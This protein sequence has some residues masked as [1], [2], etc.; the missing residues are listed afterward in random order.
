MVFLAPITLLGLLLVSLPVAI[1]LLV[2]RRGRR[3][4]FP[5]LK[6]LRETPS[7]KLYP[8]R[9]RQP[10]LLA[11]RAAAIIL[12]VMGLARP[13]FTSSAQ[14]PE[15][16]RFILID[17]SLSMKMRGRAETASEQARAII[18]KL[19][20]S[21]R[22]SVIALSS[23]AMVLAELT[24]DRE[25]LL[26]AVE[27]YQPTGG[28]VNYRAGFAA[29]RAQL[30]IEPQ[31]AV[32]ADIISDFQE[33][34]FEERGEVISPEAAQFR[35]STYEIGSE[36]ERNAFLT[37]EA[38]GKTER[39]FELSASEIV[40]EAEGRSGARR[41]WTIEG[42]EVASPEIE[43]RTQ[44][45]NQITGR[46]KVLEPDDFDADDERFFAFTPPGENRVLLA[47]D[48]K[49]A[50]LY[51]NAALEAGAGKEAAMR[52]TLDRRKSLPE[53][54]ADLA[55]FSLIVVT[56]HGGA[57]ENEARTLTEYAR[58]GGTV[59]MLTAR[60]LDAASWSQLASAEAGQE[61]PF[62]SVTR[63]N[64]NQRLTFGAMDTDAPQLRELDESALA[65]LRSVRV[66][67]SYVVTPRPQTD[68][69]MRW[70]DGTPAFIS[71]RVGSGT[72]MLLATSPERASSE[73]GL[74][75]SFPALVS[76]IS[77]AARKS[78]EPL[79][80]VIGEAVR[81]NVS[82]ETE[83]QITNAQGS[84]SMAKAS[85]L[86]R[87]PLVYF[88]EPGIYQVEFAGQQKFMAFNAPVFES[89]RALATAQDIKRR[90]SINEA[91]SARVID[92]GNSREA[93]E[94]SGSLWRYFLIAAFLLMIA[95]LFVAMRGHR[96]SIEAVNE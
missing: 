66:N 20:S 93:T 78:R 18:N 31:V 43:W 83:V 5:S 94:R 85:E 17:A 92:A 77:S 46:L 75:P 33:A 86:V 71:A 13:L 91:Q 41:A 55:S 96:K 82:L 76:S 90:F 62:E 21:E 74:S 6:F 64:G 28:A 63:R 73:L 3:L 48:G 29:I 38:V 22:A 34:G 81:L 52:F 56:L 7:F 72:I 53:S 25:R 39:G 42:S 84:V 45:N 50:S 4:D 35:I 54:A 58:A 10:L 87:R 60:D 67:E 61:L 19:R 51:L 44:A 80:H 24:E 15:A 11:L 79:S 2:R 68:T 36:I 8:R 49:D 26:K 40:S 12:L 37:D 16:V 32:Q 27:G 88:S 1:H 65:A 14:T 57:R 47:K 69:L 59:W 30:L 70:S 89:E 9:I 95:E 23:E